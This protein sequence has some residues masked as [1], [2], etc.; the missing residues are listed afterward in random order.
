MRQRNMAVS[1]PLQSAEEAFFAGQDIVEVVRD[2]F[3]Q[4]TVS[5]TVD[6]LPWFATL[7]SGTAVISDDGAGGLLVVT[8]HTD[9]NDFVNVQLNG[10]SIKLAAGKRASFRSR[11]KVDDADT[12]NFF[13][14]FAIT[15]AEILNA[16]GTGAGTVTDAIGFANIAGSVYCVSSKNGSTTWNVVAQDSGLDM[17]DATFRTFELEFDGIGGVTWKID[18]N[19]VHTIS[20]TATTIT[21]YPDDEAMTP[22]IEVQNTDA[23][24]EV[25]TVDY[26]AAY[27]ER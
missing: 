8:T 18:G 9:D 23:S 24:A 15:D 2:D 13:I 6:L 7:D 22:T 21:L 4:M 16:S 11:A 1:H 3:T 10:E 19:T 25:L 20:D 12:T 17:V 26:Y 27:Q 14:G 5:S